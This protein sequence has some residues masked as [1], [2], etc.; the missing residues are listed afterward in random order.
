MAEDLL[1]IFGNPDLVKA[2]EESNV[3]KDVIIRN[4]DVRVLEVTHTIASGTASSTEV[5]QK[6]VLL[7]SFFD[8]QM[9]I[10]TDKI[11]TL[12]TIIDRLTREKLSR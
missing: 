5:V 9:L 7:Y 3:F 8:N 1:P 2:S 12:Q 4:K 10:I 11:E 6:P